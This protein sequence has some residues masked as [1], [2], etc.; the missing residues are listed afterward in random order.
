MEQKNHSVKQLR[1]R[2]FFMILPLLT[3][4][5]LTL[6]FWALGGGKG[7]DVNAQTNL[8]AGINLKL[9]DAK[10]KDDKHFNKLSFYQQA[11]LDS[12]KVKEEEKLDPYWNKSFAHFSDSLSNNE[13][14]SLKD[15][16]TSPLASTGMDANKMKVYSKLD[17]LKKALNNSQSAANYNKQSNN[18]PYSMQ[19]YSSSNDV[20]R[21][22]AIMQK[23][24][25]EKTEDPEITQLNSML[26]KI[27]A[28]QNPDQSSANSKTTTNASLSVKLKTQTGSISLLKA[29]TAKNDSSDTI[30]E[31][32]TSNGFY[33]YTEFN[34][35][36]DSLNG[37]AIEAAIPEAQSIVAG[38]TVKLALSN[39][40]TINDVV[41]PSGTLVY[42][43]ASLSN[44]R[45]KISITSIRF[46]NSILPVS[47]EVYDMDGQQGIYVPGSINRTVAKESAN[48]AVSGIGTATVEPSIGAQAASAGIEAA[49]TLFTKKVK[50]IK[51][52]IKA[53]YK[54]LLRDRHDK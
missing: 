25:D 30:I 26:D 12:A 41:L 9:P 22:Q 16:G 6:M 32:T 17:E 24:K 5:F 35:N 2:K 21:L 27:M 14:F 8:H 50:L 13:S 39:D 15:G 46:Q 3:V 54:V 4:P 28:I 1:Q 45:L 10:F 31:T 18:R 49:K 34:S 40:V 53:G 29:D 11:A 48:N 20:A 33:T 44:E 19:S 23:M 52:T 43:T 38:A 51:L 36:N 37:N 7:N 42:G 47:L